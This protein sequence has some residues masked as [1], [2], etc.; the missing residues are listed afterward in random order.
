[1]KYE[2][3]VYKFTDGN[4]KIKMSLGKY[5]TVKFNDSK[6]NIPLDEV[7]FLGGFIESCKYDISN[8]RC[9]SGQGYLC[10]LK[11]RKK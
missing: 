10:S 4:N 5:I 9:D 7:R 2:K 1:M 6:I 3:P 11:R 8:L